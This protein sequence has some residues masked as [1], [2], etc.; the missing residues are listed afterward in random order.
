ME[1]TFSF[2]LF[3]PGSSSSAW[4]AVTVRAVKMGGKSVVRGLTHGAVWFLITR[5]VGD[6]WEMWHSC[7]NC[8]HGFAHGLLLR[9]RSL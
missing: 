2:V 5:T 7:G 8:G 6:P 4:K 3:S 1:R 9:P